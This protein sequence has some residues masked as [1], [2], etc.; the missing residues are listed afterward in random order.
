MYGNIL[1][2]IILL[3]LLYAAFTDCEGKLL[4]MNPGPWLTPSPAVIG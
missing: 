1:I 3:A 4:F 2:M